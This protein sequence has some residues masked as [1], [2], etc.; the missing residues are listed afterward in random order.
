MKRIKVDSEEMN[1]HW[2]SEMRNEIGKAANVSAE[3]GE[4]GFTPVPETYDKSPIELKQNEKRLK[5]AW[6]DFYNSL[7]EEAKDEIR[8]QLE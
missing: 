3:S 6:K 5:R 2:L 4:A 7:D 1:D 8:R